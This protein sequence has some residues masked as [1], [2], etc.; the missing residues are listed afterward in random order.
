MQLAILFVSELERP[1][2]DNVNMANVD[3][4]IECVYNII[5]A[6]D[7]DLTIICV[8]EVKP[9]YLT[10]ALLFFELANGGFCFYTTFD[11]PV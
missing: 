11:G 6:S 5:E 2:G 10:T 8:K 9:K 1:F 4:I 3:L 7:M